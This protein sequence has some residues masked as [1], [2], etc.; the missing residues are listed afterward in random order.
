MDQQENAGSQ[1]WKQDSH[2]RLSGLKLDGSPQTEDYKY[3]DLTEYNE[4]LQIQLH[5]S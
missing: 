2:E 4:I 1:N 5:N 3:D